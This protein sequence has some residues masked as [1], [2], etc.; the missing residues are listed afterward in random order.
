MTI[1][2]AFNGLAYLV[3]SSNPFIQESGQRAV[4]IYNAF[5]DN[6]LTADEF[7]EMIEDIRVLKPIGDDEEFVEELDKLNQVLTALLTVTGRK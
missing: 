1:E 6:D 5:A 7:E 4:D 2:E 3:K